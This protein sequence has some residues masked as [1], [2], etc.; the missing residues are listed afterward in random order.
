V[1]TMS[2]NLMTVAKD[3]EDAHK[4]AKKLREK[5]GKAPADKVANAAS[6]VETAQGQWESQAPYVFEQLQAADESRLNHLRTVLTQYQTHVIESVS[7]VS[8]SAGECVNALLNVQVADEVKTFAM[9]ANAGQPSVQ[10][11][12][13]AVAPSRP[14]GSAHGP[15]TSLAPTT[16]ASQADD[17]SSLRSSS[18]SYI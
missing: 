17:R 15:S 1:P 16:S 2:G 10:R 6:M 12:T 3:L 4:A 13:S 7:A 9:K 18:G 14:G 5:G 11:D 8:S